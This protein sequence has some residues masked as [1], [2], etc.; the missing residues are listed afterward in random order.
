MIKLLVRFKSKVEDE[1]KVLSDIVDIG[2]FH[3]AKGLEWKNVAESASNPFQTELE[4]SL[5]K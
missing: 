1:E 4:W 2:T 5:E 3:G